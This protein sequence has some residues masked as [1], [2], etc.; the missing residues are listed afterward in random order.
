VCDGVDMCL[1]VDVKCIYY[2]CICVDVLACWVCVGDCV[3]VLL[4]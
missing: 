2:C 4:L 1:C 3:N